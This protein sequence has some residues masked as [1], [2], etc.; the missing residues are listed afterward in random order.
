MTGHSYGHRMTQKDS[1]SVR[2]LKEN[3]CMAKVWPV[4]E[5]RRP[6]VGEPWAEL[7]LEDAIRV[8]DLEPAHFLTD[9]SRIPKFGDTERDRTWIGY[10]HVVVEV[11]DHEAKAGWKSG[12]FRSPLDPKEGYFRLQVHQ[13]LG[14]L[15]RDE[16]KKGEDAE[17]EPAMWLWAVLKAEAP[18]AEW[19][20]NNRERIQAEVRQAATESGVSE[21]VFVRFRK[22]KEERAAS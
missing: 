22:E 9:L 13:R 16:W 20:W 17:G 3:R 1:G 12:F 6:T 8:L 11:G 18:D 7:P 2:R 4:Y 5:G 19:A 14:E 15:W 21:W 10:R